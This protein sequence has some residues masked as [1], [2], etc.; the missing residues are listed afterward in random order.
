SRQIIRG[1]DHGLLRAFEHWT[2]GESN[3]CLLGYRINFLNG[4]VSLCSPIQASEEFPNGEVIHASTLL[5]V[6]QD[7]SRELKRMIEIDSPLERLTG[8]GQRW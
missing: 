7:L 6:G 2:L 3:S 8:Q 1:S 4:K 5:G